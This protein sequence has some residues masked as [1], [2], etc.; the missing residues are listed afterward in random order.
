M[1]LGNTTETD[2]L[3]S[4]FN[5][6][7]PGWDA[8]SNFWVALYTADPGEAGTA[9]TNETAYGSYARVAVARNSGGFTISV[10]TVS[11]TALVQF[12]I[13]TSG[14]GTVSHFAIVTTAS[15]AGQIILRGALSST[16]STATGIQPQFA[17]GALTATID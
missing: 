11:N 12:P 15:G 1:S 16:V 9:T 7:D 14:T 17:A 10:N 3:T 5:N 8:N 6:T 13:S 2:V 4:M